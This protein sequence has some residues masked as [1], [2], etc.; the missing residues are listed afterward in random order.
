MLGFE[1]SRVPSYLG[2]LVLPGG[3]SSFGEIR[4]EDEGG[5]TLAPREM[6]RDEFEEKWVE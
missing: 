6:N 3:I 2:L 5:S 1:F 4:T